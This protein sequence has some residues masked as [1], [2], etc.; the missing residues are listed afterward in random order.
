MKNIE[1]DEADKKISATKKY[2]MIRYW[3]AELVLI[4]GGLIL[5][6]RFIGNGPEDISGGMIIGWGR[7]REFT[8]FKYYLSEN[9]GEFVKEFYYKD[10]ILFLILVAVVAVLPYVVFPAVEKAGKYVSE[11]RYR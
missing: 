8:F 4:F 11:H 6:S 2:N 5:G 7:W 3:L 1:T 10:I 9:T